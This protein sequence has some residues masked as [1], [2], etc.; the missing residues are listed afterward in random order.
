MKISKK[1]QYGLRAMAFLAKKYEKKE[2]LSLKE[3]SSE[4]GISFDYLEKIL[5]DLERAGLVKGKRGRGGGYRLSKSPKKVTVGEI[6]RALEGEINLVNCKS[7]KCPKIKKC[8][9]KDV[10]GKLQKTI[11]STL[12][13]ITLFNLINKKI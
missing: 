4:E 9:T 12:D 3:I 2:I 6:I 1:S 5:I 11:L 10:W 13:S 7:E 8:L